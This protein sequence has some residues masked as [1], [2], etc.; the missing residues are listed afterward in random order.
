MSNCTS[1][2]RTKDHAS[3]AEC[4]KDKGVGAVGVDIS[5]GHEASRQKKWDRELDAY[6]D[7]R[8]QGV[9]PAGTKMR[10]VDAAMA[11]SNETGKAFD[12]GVQ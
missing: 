8:R 10:D 7:A 5:K 9:Q 4:L 3:Y 6:A 1:G 11:I 2:C 12:A